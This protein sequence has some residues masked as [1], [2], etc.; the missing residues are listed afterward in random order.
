M[1][2]PGW[3]PAQP[4]LLRKNIYPDVPD[5]KNIRGLGDG[6]CVVSARVVRQ[7]YAS[8]IYRIRPAEARKARD[9]PSAIG[10]TLGETKQ[11]K[12]RLRKGP[13]CDGGSAEASQASGTARVGT[14]H[15]VSDVPAGGR[16]P[17]LR[18]CWPRRAAKTR[19]GVG[20]ELEHSGQKGAGINQLIGW[21]ERSLGIR[22]HSRPQHH[23][24]RYTLVDA[25]CWESSSIQ[26]RLA[27]LSRRWCSTGLIPRR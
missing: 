6:V 7:C 13:Q 2:Y 21:F 19:F 10:C 27:A 22:M 12:R 4:G 23:L 14:R 17:I 26:S 8:G 15:C 16:E 18:T 3:R 20:I 11:P 9:P 24:A 25:I 5:T 1:L